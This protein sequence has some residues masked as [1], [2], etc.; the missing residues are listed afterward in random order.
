MQVRAQYFRID[1]YIVQL[2]TSNEVETLHR[3]LGISASELFHVL[4]FIY[5]VLS[6]L[7]LQI[8]ELGRRRII[9]SSMSRQ[10]EKSNLIRNTLQ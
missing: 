10:H 8:R 5:V 3:L 2:V 9:G 6:V 1:Y 4:V 7:L